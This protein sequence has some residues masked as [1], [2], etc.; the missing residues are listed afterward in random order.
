[1]MIFS[2]LLLKGKDIKASS[3][4]E[5]T[6]GLE[7]Y[8]KA[9]KAFDEVAKRQQDGQPLMPEESALLANPEYATL[10]QDR[11]RFIRE[12]EHFIMED[13]TQIVAMEPVSSIVTEDLYIG[14][15]VDGRYQIEGVIGSGGMG[16]VYRCKH[17][18]L[19]KE[20]AMKVLQ[21]RLAAMRHKEAE[22]KMSELR[23][24]QRSIE[25]GNQIRSYVFQPYTLVKDHRT[26][27]EVG[28]IIAV[29][30]GEIDPLIHAYLTQFRGNGG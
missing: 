5:F 18:A 3:L 16:V 28:N 24:V 30:E 17:I 25:W 29:M 1:M 19:G 2:G 15:I 23:G 14:Q 13:P 4:R 10:K 11:E 6:D 9:L 26:N 7:K 8:N 21:S 27:T 12:S 22:A 20:F